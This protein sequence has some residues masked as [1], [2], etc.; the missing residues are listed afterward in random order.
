MQ[1]PHASTVGQQDVATSKS[2]FKKQAT[3]QC[4]SHKVKP[5][6][7]PAV[8]STPPR[9]LGF[10]LFR[11]RGEQAGLVGLAQ[12]QAQVH[13]LKAKLAATEMI[14]DIAANISTT[15]LS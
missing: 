4:W 6:L 15:I 2:H 13:E 14:Q 11:G 9:L 3:G 10:L 7:C 1:M 8:G 5:G 12:R